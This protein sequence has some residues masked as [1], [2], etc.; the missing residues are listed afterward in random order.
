MVSGIIRHAVRLPGQERLIAVHPGGEVCEFSGQISR[1]CQRDA[2]D[3]PFV[4][5]S[6]A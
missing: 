4:T 6:A 1:R 2:V 5:S 3:R